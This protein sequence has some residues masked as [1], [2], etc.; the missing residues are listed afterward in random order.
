MAVGRARDGWGWADARGGILLPSKEDEALNM[1]R[2]GVKRIL[3]GRGVTT[4]TVCKVMAGKGMGED[5]AGTDL[6][7]NCVAARWAMRA[8]M[9]K[10]IDL[11]KKAG[12]IEGR[13]K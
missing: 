8:N 12:V 11:A 1:V 9:A 10:R 6:V 4:S 13:G 3:D 7:W 5:E 2:D